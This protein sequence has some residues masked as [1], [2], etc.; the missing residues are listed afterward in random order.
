M[1]THAAVVPKTQTKHTTTRTTEN[2][3][4]VRG[5]HDRFGG[6]QQCLCECLIGTAAALFPLWHVCDDCSRVCGTLFACLASGLAVDRAID[7]L[8]GGRG[9]VP[10][11]AL[12]VQEPASRGRYPPPSCW[13]G[14]MGPLHPRLLLCGPCCAQ[15]QEK[16]SVTVAVRTR[17][18]AVFAQ[19]QVILDL[20]SNVL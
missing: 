10:A 9:P 3:P 14:V 17:P 13:A 20:E 11:P 19:D 15:L 1:S 12:V 5:A 7:R 18:T 8:W 4:Y 6:C 16:R 2:M